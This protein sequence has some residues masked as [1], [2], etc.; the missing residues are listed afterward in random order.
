MYKILKKEHHEIV[1][2][3]DQISVSKILF[4]KYLEYVPPP[5]DIMKLQKIKEEKNCQI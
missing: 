1:R 5:P 2:A 4:S 3:G